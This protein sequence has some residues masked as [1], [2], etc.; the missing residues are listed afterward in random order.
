MP[1][2]VSSLFQ[3]SVC[4]LLTAS[5]AELVLMSVPST[6]QALFATVTI[7]F[8][9]LPVPLCDVQASTGVVWSTPVSETAPPTMPPGVPPIVIS[10]VCVPVVVVLSSRHIS[11]RFGDESTVHAATLVKAVVPSSLTVETV[12][13]ASVPLS[14]VMFA[15]MM[16]LFAETMVMLILQVAEASVLQLPVASKA[17][18]AKHWRL[19]EPQ[20][21]I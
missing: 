1:S 8:D 16:P 7:A 18:A 14:A 4:P 17:I 9:G 13:F 15:T 11:E 10:T 6:I 2:V 12:R 19:R 21:A 20:I 5:D 3:R